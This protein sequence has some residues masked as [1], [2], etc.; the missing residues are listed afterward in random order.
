[1]EFTSDLPHTTQNEPTHTQFDDRVAEQRHM[2]STLRYPDPYSGSPLFPSSMKLSLTCDVGDGT[3]ERSLVL[4]FQ[5]A[6]VRVVL[7]LPPGEPEL[8]SLGKG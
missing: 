7:Q 1:M 4:F 8:A 3:A 2:D 5:S 6:Y